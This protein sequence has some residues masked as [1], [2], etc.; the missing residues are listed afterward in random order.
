MEQIKKALLKYK[1]VNG[2]H[3]WQGAL[4]CGYGQVHINKKVYKIHRLSYE[5]YK[6]KIPPRMYVLHT[7]DVRNCFN[8][9]HLVLGTHQDNMD[10]KVQRRRHHA[11]KITHCPYGHEYTKENTYKYKGKRLCRMCRKI[12]DQL[13]GGWKQRKRIDRRRNRRVKQTGT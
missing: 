10:H 12:R 4:A 8:P 3:L 2:C 13:N 7:C 5:H 1:K 6:E 11:Y 9:D